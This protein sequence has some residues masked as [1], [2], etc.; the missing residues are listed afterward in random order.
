MNTLYYVVMYDHKQ[1]C[2]LRFAITGD[3]AAKSEELRR[4]SAVD[5]VLTLVLQP[6]ALHVERVQRICETPNDIFEEL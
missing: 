6:K 1:N 5:R 2:H 4:Q 3:P